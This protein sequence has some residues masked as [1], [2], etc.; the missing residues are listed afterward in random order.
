MG[1]I[2]DGMEI[3]KLVNKAQNAE[4]Y[5][6][7]GEWI[8][9]VAELQRENEKLTTE[10]NELREKLR[11]KGVLQRINGHTFLEGDDEEICPRCAEVD[12][13]PVHLIPRVPQESGWPCAAC[14]QCKIGS[15]YADP[16]TRETAKAIR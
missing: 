9:K 15:S 10:R 12:S 7:I 11:F 5:K 16:L 14:P 1:L 13:R 2:G 8:D 3:L 6:Q 4:L